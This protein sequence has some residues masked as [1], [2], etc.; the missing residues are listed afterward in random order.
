[1]TEDEK[2]R[3]EVSFTFP[4]CQS[5]AAKNRTVPSKLWRL[6]SGPSC[7]A[8]GLI[9]MFVSVLSSKLLLF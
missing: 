6:P 5:S 3:G 7:Q 2:Q 4:G 8:R 9:A 1:M